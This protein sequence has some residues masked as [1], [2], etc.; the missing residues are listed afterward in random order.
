[1]YIVTVGLLMYL[2]LIF[3]YIHIIISYMKFHILH[4]ISRYLLIILN[5]F[6]SGLKQM[7]SILHSIETISS[8]FYSIIHIG[9]PVLAK[10]FS[11]VRK[12]GHCN[13]NTGYT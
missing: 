8:F 1:M 2:Y 4:I 10:S 5:I 3:L 9:H 12:L 11:S 13:F 6:A 7:D